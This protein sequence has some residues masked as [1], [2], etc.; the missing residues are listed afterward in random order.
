MNDQMP[1]PIRISG[2][3]KR[4]QPHSSTPKLWARNKHPRTMRMM[5]LLFM[6][7]PLLVGR[8]LRLM[9]IECRMKQAPVDRGLSVQRQA[10]LERLDAHRL[11]ILRGLDCIAHL[12]TD[13]RE[14]RLMRPEA[15]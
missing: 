1:K 15:A 4:S 9:V 13:P 6:S 12:P 3:H 2:H 8:E 10:K 14:P 11:T 5:P 7:K